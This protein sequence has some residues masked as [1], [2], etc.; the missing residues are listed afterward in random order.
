MRILA[1]T[2]KHPEDPTAGGGERCLVESIGSRLAASGPREWEPNSH[3][4]V[5]LFGRFAATHAARIRRWPAR[6]RHAPRSTTPA[7]CGHHHA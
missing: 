1:L 7:S 4:A 6:L 5:S 3:S 2:W